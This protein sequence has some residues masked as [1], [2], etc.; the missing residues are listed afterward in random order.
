MKNAVKSRGQDMQTTILEVAERLFAEIG[1]EKTTVA[2][3]AREMHMSPA[4]V[5]RFFSSKAEINEAAARRLLAEVV[6]TVAKIASAADPAED[7][8][9]AFLAGLEKA[10]ADRFL[11][12]RKLHELVEAAFD[13][14]W[15][16]AKEHVEAIT[17]LLSEILSQGDCDGAFSVGDCDLGAILVRSA[18]MQFYHPRLMVE[19]AQD[20]EPTLDQMV[21]FCLNA[22]SRGAPAKKAHARIVA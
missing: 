2:D 12:H 20:P 8:L 7:K 9:R 17:G 6:A 10:N 22:L 14:N 18:C 3:I 11:N 1:F 13:E 4:N 19:C 16:P 15:P 5:Y 21:D